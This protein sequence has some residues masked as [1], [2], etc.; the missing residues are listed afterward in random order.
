MHHRI[1]L[2]PDAQGCSSCTLGSLC[3][4]TGLPPSERGVFDRL[5]KE[6]LQVE[7]GDIIYQQQASATAI[8]GIHTGALKTLF[9]DADGRVQITCFLLPGEVAGLDG[10]VGSHYQTHA[11]ALE[12]TEL[13]VVRLPDIERVIRALPA[14]HRQFLGLLNQRLIRTQ[15]LLVS[16]GLLRPE[17]RLAFFL[18]DLSRRRQALGDDPHAFSL[19]MGREDIGNHLGLTKETVSRL[20]SRFAQDNVIRLRSRQV[21]LLDV[22]TLRELAGVGG[23]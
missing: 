18:L 15:Q 5:V 8:Y 6:R 21:Q 4:P 2:R 10:Y 16:L 14:L 12:D 22:P 17:Q 13:C 3:L 20:F 19:F 9:E 7:R 1:A 23:S 11:V